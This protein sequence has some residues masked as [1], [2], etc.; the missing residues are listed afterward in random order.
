[1]NPARSFGPSLAA[2]IYNSWHVGGRTT[3]QD[4]WSYQYV[5]W[6]GPLLGAVLAAL[7]YKYAMTDRYVGH[8]IEE[9]PL[10]FRILLA[11]DEKRWFFRKPVPKDA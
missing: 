11:D 5:Y 4:P 10:C 1:M 8:G 9:A 3:K 7:V 2:A 6:V